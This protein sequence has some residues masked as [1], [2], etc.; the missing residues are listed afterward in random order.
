M[1]VEQGLEGVVVLGVEDRVERLVTAALDLPGGHQPGVDRVAELGDDD[2]IVDGVAGGL[3][4]GVR[5]LLADEVGHPSIV[6][7]A[8]PGDSPEPAVDAARLLAA[9]R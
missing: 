5:V 2:Q 9:R 6:G 8:D 1:G 3:G 7:P 4:V